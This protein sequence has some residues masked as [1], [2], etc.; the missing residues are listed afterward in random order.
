VVKARR[1]TGIVVIG[2]NEALRLGR[3]LASVL[4]FGVPVV[5]VGSGSDGSVA[6]ATEQAAE[7]NVYYEPAGTVLAALRN[8]PRM[9]APLRS[10]VTRSFSPADRRR[11]R[12]VPFSSSLRRFLRW[13]FPRRGL[14][15]FRRLR[16][17]RGSRK[18]A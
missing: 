17:Q 12:N 2:R 5:Y 4:H 7:P 13:P 6:L 9:G 16:L 1:K 8:T 18:A 3:G 11:T 14:R 15:G 10:D